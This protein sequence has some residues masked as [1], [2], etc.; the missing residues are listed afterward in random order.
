MY[1]KLKFYEE[2]GV[3]EYYLYDPDH[4]DLEGWL[5]DLEGLSEIRDMAGWTSP[6]LGVRF[7]TSGD[8]LRIY[9]PD[10]RRFLTFQE[11]AA[12]REL[13][14]QDR[15]RLTKDRDIERHRAERMA[16]QLRA[17]GVEPVE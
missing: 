14:L 16:A 6:R 8:E 1:R 4:D 13:A 9:G 11:L 15:D 7:D 12:E 17:L 3:E 10:G 5:R 2:Y